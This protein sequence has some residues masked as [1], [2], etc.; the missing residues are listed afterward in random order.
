MSVKISPQELKDKIK[1]PLLLPLLDHWFTA[2]GEKLFPSRQDI[3]P[4]AFFRTLRHIW[5]MEYVP[6]L[7]TYRYCLTGE[8]VNLSSEQSIIG[9]TVEETHPSSQIDEVKSHLDRVRQEKS[10]MIMHGET[11]H[12]NGLKSQHERIIFPLSSNGKTV[13]EM[14]GATSYQRPTGLMGEVTGQNI[15]KCD[16]YPV[17]NFDD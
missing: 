12:V 16:V 13:T 10:I 15:N 17:N 2:R 8:E 14:I 11:L 9:Q 3:D 1:S 5:I 4:V 6:D 7:E